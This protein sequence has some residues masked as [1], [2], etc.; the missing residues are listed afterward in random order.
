M[1]K[2]Y[3]KPE[4]DYVKGELVLYYDVT[5]TNWSPKIGGIK[6]VGVEFEYLDGNDARILELE[7]NGWAEVTDP[8]V[9]DDQ[10]V[11]TKD[12]D[13]DKWKLRV[14]VINTLRIKA[15]ESPLAI[16]AKM[17][18]EKHQQSIK[19]YID[20]GSDKLLNVFETSEDN[21]IDLRETPESASPRETAIAALS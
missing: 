3:V 19:D 7:N 17:F 14:E 16:P 11:I 13:Y 21:W 1:S 15:E 4:S 6:H 8:S 10:Q 2:T 18:Y 9:F 5:P 20:S 12:G